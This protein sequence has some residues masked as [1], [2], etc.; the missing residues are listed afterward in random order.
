MTQIDKDFIEAKLDSISDYQEKIEKIFEF[1]ITEIKKD[2]LKLHAAERLLQLI[3]DTMIDINTH[4]IRRQNLK[5]ASDL[6]S[7]FVILSK[8]KI[9]DE[10]FAEKLAPITGMRNRIIHRYEA[11]DIDLFL[12]TFAKQKNDF[13]HYAQAIESYLEHQ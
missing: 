3:V 10:N 13:V 7:T 6:Y 8:N 1:D 9:L 5:P 4:I 11:V 2:F 12:K